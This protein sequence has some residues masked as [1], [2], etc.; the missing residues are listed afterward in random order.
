MTSN[1]DTEEESNA[2]TD[3]VQPDSIDDQLDQA[4]TTLTDH[5]NEIDEL[6][7]QATYV[8]DEGDELRNWDEARNY[9]ETGELPR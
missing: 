5:L 1:T 6:M 4:L 8:T 7:P 3:I 2:E 9:L